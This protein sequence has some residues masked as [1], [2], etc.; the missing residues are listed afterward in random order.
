MASYNT[1]LS[2][3]AAF[4]FSTPDHWPKWKRCFQQYR[5][6]SRLSQESEEHQVNT[7]LYCLSEEAKDILAS[8]NIG[9]ED[10]KKHDS[11]LAKFDS[12]FSV[13][14][15]VIIECTKFNKRFQLPDESVE[16]FIA[17][18]YNLADC[19]LGELKD[20]LIH[21]RIVVEIRDAS[22]SERL[23]MDLELTLEKSKMV[24]RQREAVCKQQVTIRG[25]I[26]R[27]SVT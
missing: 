10:R 19:N 11:I 15:Y 4:P 24:V 8:A 14:K 20:E 13:R 16:Q 18:L 1:L 5:L 27:S 3:P 9:E 7:L 2:V 25:Q 22:L 6:A 17:S 26:R 12:F 23:Q 21:D